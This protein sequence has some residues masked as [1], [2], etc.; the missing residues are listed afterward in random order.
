MFYLL[1]PLP[2]P[3]WGVYISGMRLGYSRGLGINRSGDAC[4]L[5]DY[6]DVLSDR[7]VWSASRWW[8]RDPLP[9][10]VL[11]PSGHASVGR[12]I[13][14][15]GTVVGTFDEANWADRKAF[16]FTTSLQS[17]D[18]LVPGG[19][20]T[21]GRGINESGAVVGEVALN[22]SWTETAGFVCDP[23]AQEARILDPGIFTDRAAAAGING[24]SDHGEIAMAADGQ[25]VLHTD[26]EKMVVA[27]SGVPFAINRGGD[28]AIS[29]SSGPA[30]YQRA[31][32]T[33]RQLGSL[34]GYTTGG[35][36]G[37]NNQG[38]VVGTCARPSP[39][40]WEQTGFVWT[41]STGMLELTSRLIGAPG[42]RVLDAWDV[43]DNGQI[44]ATGSYLGVMSAVRLDPI[45]APGSDDGLGPGFADPEGG[46]PIAA[47]VL[48]VAFVLQQH[49]RS[50]D[51]GPPKTND[52]DAV[53]EGMRSAQLSLLD[54]FANLLDEGLRERYRRAGV[55]IEV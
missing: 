34:G 14:D 12:R 41:H 8:A 29:Q 22:P 52:D 28:I 36:H 31:T 5:V 39:V 55:T 6:P 2:P 48:N 10:E 20:E 45:G 1:I 42:W 27:P 25:T 50:I 16:S 43:N 18:P 47:G 26:D 7:W 33:L 51:F 23:L 40:G 9:S 13:N 49:L 44:V 46:W 37:L 3:A 30:L 32:K 4:G 19:V 54:A 17:I 24:Q 11:L 53:Q 15:R 38:T 35:A 21:D